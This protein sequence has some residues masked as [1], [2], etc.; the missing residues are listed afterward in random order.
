MTFKSGSEYLSPIT[1]PTRQRSKG[2]FVPNPKGPL[3]EQVHEVM[4]FFHYAEG[5]EVTYWQWIV[6]D[7]RF[8]R[9]GNG[10]GRTN[11]TDGAG[12][13]AEAGTANCKRLKNGVNL[14]VAFS[15]SPHSSALLGR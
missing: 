6:R 14:R 15:A 9:R 13:P 2:K 8:H 1:E 12:E 10:A 11:A 5:T 3:R 4:R 7:L